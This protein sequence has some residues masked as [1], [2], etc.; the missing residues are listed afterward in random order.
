M[1]PLT[2]SSLSLPLPP[3]E[4]SYREV[5]KC[6]S[7][8]IEEA[9]ALAYLSDGRRLRTDNVSILADVHDQTIFVFNKYYLDRD[10]DEVA[11][12]LHLQ[13]PLQPPIGES[14]TTTPPELG[15]MF[16]LAAQTHLQSISRIVE[17]MR[18]QR[19]ALQLASRVVEL[20]VLN[21]SDVVSD[22][23]Q[24]LDK[25]AALVDSIHRGFMSPAVLRAMDAGG[26][27]RTLGHYVSSEKLCRA[28]EDFRG[29]QERH[30]RI[31][32]TVKQFVDGANEGR[33]ICADV[34]FVS[35][36]TYLARKLAKVTSVLDAPIL[37]VEPILQELRSLDTS[38]RDN[39]SS[40]VESKNTYTNQCLY[41]LRRIHSLNAGLVTLSDVFNVLQVSLH[42]KSSFSDIER[43]H[44]MVYAYGATMV[45]VVHRKE[46]STLFHRK[47]QRFSEVMSNL[48]V[49][50]AERRQAFRDE[51]LGQLPF[52][53]I[54]M[55][56]TLPFVRISVSEG[57]GTSS[58]YTLVR[59]DISDLLRDL[60]DSRLASNDREAVPAR[61]QEVCAN[62]EG[63][64]GKIDA[65]E[66]GFTDLV[67][68]SLISKGLAQN[69]KDSGSSG[70]GGALL[71]KEEIGTSEPEVVVI[72]EQVHAAVNDNERVAQLERELTLARAQL[73]SE[74]KARHAL[75]DQFNGVCAIVEQY[76]QGRNERVQPV[77]RE[78]HREIHAPG[79]DS[80]RLVVQ[81]LEVTAAYRRTCLKALALAQAQTAPSVRNDSDV[82]EA[83]G[84]QPPPAEL[85]LT[86][87]AR[88]IEVLRSFD[89]DGFLQ[90]ITKTGS[91]IR[92]WQKHCKNYRERSKGKISF[93]D[94]AEGDLALFLPTRNSPTR[95]WAAFN[96]SYPHYC[97][98]ENGSLTEQLKTREWLV[99]RITS[100]L[101][102]V[103]DPNDPES[104]P[105][106][107]GDG[108]KYHMLQV[109]D[110]TQPSKQRPSKKVRLAGAAVAVSDAGEGA[111]VPEE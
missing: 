56:E 10:P 34:G 64:V 53:L 81:L 27:P 105:Y 31:E 11:K 99:A 52:D 85:D 79:A 50:E 62:L 14:Q 59:R 89:H 95:P 109:E 98:L 21:I 20:H 26:A 80:D 54:G 40:V 49:A 96:V 60:K 107:L 87:P 7:V 13:P 70:T 108:V 74:R 9:A 33:S 68:R 16:H 8:G 66:S 73:E 41:A 93:R 39:L 76:K 102:R 6:F 35:V 30:R 17:S 86:D 57:G 32:A 103:V 28:V 44:N 82:D 1:A 58:H 15:A 78:A 18:H 92:K 42:S 23:H 94:F 77:E 69:S 61:V 106:G 88:A 90:A 45:E 67:E 101:E 65:L 37:N 104:N 51:I 43:L 91:T 111:G 22:V 63:L 71:D 2:C 75:E 46:F 4:L 100:I 19:S 48:S 84:P 25:R 38:I 3:V 83:P 29:L 24:E 97:L 47:C 72:E 36:G 5:S 110:W 55:D 12:L